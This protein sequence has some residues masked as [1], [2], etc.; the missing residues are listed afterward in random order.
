MSKATETRLDGRVA[1]VTGAGRGIGRSIAIGLAAMGAKVALASRSEHELDEVASVIATQGGTAIT[2]LADVGN[3]D[4]RQLML[5]RVT[6][7]LGT[8]E[9]LINNAAVVWPVAASTTVDIDDYAAAIDIN[10]IG[11]VALSFA[12]LPQMLA[13][14]WGRIINVSSGI[15]GRPQGMIGAN[16]YATSKAALEAHTINLATEL[17]GSGVAINAYRPGQVDTAMQGWIRAQPPEKVGAELHGRFVA[18]LEEGVLLSADESAAG[19]LYRI[20]S[21]ESGQIWN[22]SDH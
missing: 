4:Q 10:V 9:I 21:D 11:V 19:L 7:Q 2:A 5:D 6:D 3:P 17:Q 8:I 13:S 15:A 12:V 16:A 14:R 18:N 1:L 20:P 22:V